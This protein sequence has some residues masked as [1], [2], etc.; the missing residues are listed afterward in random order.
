MKDVKIP[1]LIRAK[2]KEA[3][4]T[5]KKLGLLCG[6]EEKSAERIVQ[7]WEHGTA[8][9]PANKLRALASALQVPLED[10]IP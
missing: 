3:G 8:E 10:L 6:Y 4:L 5:Q 9:A 7:H 2:R 1:E